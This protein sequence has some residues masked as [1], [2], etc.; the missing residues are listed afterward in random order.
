MQYVISL[1]A[2]TSYL[3]MQ[4]SQMPIRYCMIFQNAIT[5]YVFLLLRHIS[6]CYYVISLYAI[7]SYLYMQLSQMPIGYCMIFQNAITSYVYLLLHHISICL[8]PSKTNGTFISLSNTQH[9]QTCSALLR[10]LLSTGWSNE[11]NIAP[12]NSM[13]KE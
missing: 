8:S 6:I 4:L 3:Y 10:A 7:T 9:L 2:I 5:S 11:L 12:K 13:N 1:Y